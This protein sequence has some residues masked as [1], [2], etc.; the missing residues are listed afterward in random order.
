MTFGP[1]SSS[2]TFRLRICNT[3]GPTA[4]VRAN[5]EPK[6]KSLVNTTKQ[7]A[8]AQAMIAIS[9]ARGVTNRHP[10]NGIPPVQGQLRNPLRRHVHVEQ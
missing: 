8:K 10:V 5:V 4:F 7:L 6:S 9:S 2:K 3:L 1:M